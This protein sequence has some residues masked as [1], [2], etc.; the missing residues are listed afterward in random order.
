MALFG[1]IVALYLLIG[2]CVAS[3]AFL[4]DTGVTYSA[5][6]NW[7]NEYHIEWKMSTVKTFFFAML[8]IIWP[9]I[10]KSMIK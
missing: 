10:L 1:A 9:V 6:A 3:Y 7:K 2:I 5:I 4:I 8:M